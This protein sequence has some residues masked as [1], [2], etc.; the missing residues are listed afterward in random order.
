MQ[1]PVCKP[2]LQ[3][4]YNRSIWEIDTDHRIGQRAEL[5]GEKGWDHHMVIGIIGEN[6]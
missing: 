3:G 1:I 4:G 5:L 2:I 6:G